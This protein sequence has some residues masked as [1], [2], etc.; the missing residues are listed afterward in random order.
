MP[1]PAS[2]GIMVSGVIGVK[3]SKSQRQYQSSTCTFSTMG[4]KNLVI[5]DITD[6]EKFQDR[7][8]S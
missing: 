1:A 6:K 3:V 8:K 5:S 4:E 2:I 7:L